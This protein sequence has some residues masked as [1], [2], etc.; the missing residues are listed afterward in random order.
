M[1]LSPASNACL[2][3]TCPLLNPSGAET[4]KVLTP[5]KFRALLEE[6]SQKEID[7][8]DFASQDFEKRVQ[9]LSPKFDYQQIVERTQ[10]CGWSEDVTSSPP[11]SGPNLYK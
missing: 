5:T 1:K 3:L 8:G 2:L 11:P 7:L 6:L 9:E 10:C 4:V